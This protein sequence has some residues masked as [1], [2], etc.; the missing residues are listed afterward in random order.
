MN[1]MKKQQ[2]AEQLKACLNKYAPRHWYIDAVYP[3]VHPMNKVVDCI[4]LTFDGGVMWKMNFV[5]NTMR[6]AWQRTSKDN[7]WMNPNP[8]PIPTGRFCSVAQFDAA[9][10]AYM[11]PINQRMSAGVAGEM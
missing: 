8:F 9:L 7:Q 11:R 3:W 6:I 2:V 1:V 5:G 10:K 4:G